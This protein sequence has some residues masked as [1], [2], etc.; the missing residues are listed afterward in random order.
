MI[1]AILALGG[2]TA[3]CT[4][5]VPPPPPPTLTASPPETDLER[6]ERLAFES[7]EH[8]Y[9]SFITEWN[10]RAQDGGLA[11]P[12][13]V[14][15]R[16]AAGDYLK[17]QTK[18]LQDRRRYKVKTVGDLRV[19]SVTPGSYSSGDLSLDSCEDGSRVKNYTSDGKLLV[20]GVI[21]RAQIRVKLIEG[22]WKL[23]DA[24]FTKVP[25]CG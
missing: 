12:N 24:A 1:G 4:P 18:Y 25:S 5:D 13:A 2:L 21:A 23:W 3:A 7:A 10:A 11:K 6:E 14:M 9:R 22:Q 20:G 19:V 16:Y 8:S 15:K 17:T